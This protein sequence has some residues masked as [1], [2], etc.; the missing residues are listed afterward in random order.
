M[1]QN[2]F[3]TTPDGKKYLYW[4]KVTGGLEVCANASKHVFKHFS[5]SKKSGNVRKCMQTHFKHSRRSKISFLK[6]K[7]LVVWKHVQMHQNTFLTTPDGKKYLFWKKVSG[8]LEVCANASKHV[9]KHSWRS[10][11]SFLKKCF[12]WSA[13]AFKHVFNHSRR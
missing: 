1:H 2:T 5:R 7:F 12:W 11:K 3:L 6:K 8:N 9:F 10:K 13:N 4:K